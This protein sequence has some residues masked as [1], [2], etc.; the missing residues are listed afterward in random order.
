MGLG[1]VELVMEI[2]DRFGINIP[3]WRAEQ[4]VTVSD[5]VIYCHQLI[6]AAH[7]RR[8]WSLPHFLMLR[9]LTR[10]FLDVPAL[11]LRPRDAVV[12]VIPPLRRASFFQKIQEASIL[13]SIWNLFIFTH[14]LPFLPPPKIHRANLELDC[15]LP[16]RVRFVL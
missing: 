4:I 5:L 1:T 2:E 16:A 10:Q 9:R 6:V 11:C 3:D 8:C 12:D 14:S 15:D 13:T 7:E